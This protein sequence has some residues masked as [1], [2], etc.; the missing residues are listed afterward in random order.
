MELQNFCFAYKK[1]A[2]ES[3]HIP[4]AKLPVGEMI[5][6]IG[7]NGAGKSTLARCVCGLEKKC[8]VLQVNGKAL[9]WKARLKHCYMVM[10]DTSHQLFTESVTN[11]ILLS[12]DDED[13]TV[14]EQILEQF[15]LLEYKDRHPLSLSG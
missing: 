7:L 14:V 6:I 4:N 15:D 11:E 8:G 2:P 9:D 13:E 10:Q 3:L 5:A 1:Q 12:M